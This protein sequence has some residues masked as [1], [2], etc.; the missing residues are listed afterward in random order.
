MNKRNL[1]PR[2]RVDATYD[3]QSAIHGIIIRTIEG[4]DPIYKSC[5]NCI[6]FSEQREGCSLANYQRPPARVIAYGC[7]QWEDIDE[8][9][10]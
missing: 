4:T 6:N 2:L 5:M 7:P 1:K 10:F 8:I 3:I 9:P